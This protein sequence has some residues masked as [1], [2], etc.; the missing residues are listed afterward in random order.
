[1]K[2]NNNR[3][4]PQNSHIRSQ[5]QYFLVGIL[6]LS[7]IPT[8]FGKSA[9]MANVSVESSV[10]QEVFPKNEPIIPHGTA[11]SILNATIHTNQTGYLPNSYA[12]ITLEITNNFSLPIQSLS[13][14]VSSFS[15]LILISGAET[16]EL[17]TLEVNQTFTRN[18][19]CQL[20]ES[21]QS[22]D[23]VFL[24]DGSGSMT[25]EIS[26]VKGKVQDLIDTLYANV[27]SVRVGIIFFGSTRYD[28][29]PYG[30]E[31]NIL[32]LTDDKDQIQSFLNPWAAGGSWE[33]WGDALHYLK[34]LDWQSSA[35]L[36]ILI[37]D[38]PCNA[39]TYV[40]DD[41]DL[42]DL[43]EEL[44]GLNIIVS[45]MQCYGG[46]EELE[47]QLTQ[48]ASITSGLFVKLEASSDELMDT[49][50]AMCYA[51]LQ[52]IGQQFIVVF[53]GTI[54]LTIETVELSRWI[55]VDNNPPSVSGNI[56]QILDTS[57]DPATFRL[58]V[59]CKVY[60]AAGVDNVTLF[61]KFNTTNFIE[62]QMDYA[63]WGT[64]SYLLPEVPED[65]T[66]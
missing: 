66:V 63:T 5:F 13:M 64:F 41:G 23:V 57:Q 49:A 19:I 27:S 42:Y 10:D 4:V 59:I 9:S 44:Q 12:N 20:P 48:I 51:A 39:G 53:S 11:D 35:R 37:T 26:E 3:S 7:I 18:L 25:D 15:D 21:S 36:A 34:Q 55:L 6:F 8:I 65:S 1:M 22:L 61:Y 52:E 47:T 43:A 45:T 14:N 30:D 38:E 2:K 16:N 62:V 40:K 54:N 17:A 56:L 33:P 24:I 46:G 31:R 28:E 29:N 60:D 32:D 50:L 58:R